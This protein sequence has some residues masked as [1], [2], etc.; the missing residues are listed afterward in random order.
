MVLK[1][2]LKSEHNNQLKFR[3]LARNGSIKELHK[4][5]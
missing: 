5:F 4:G 1:E 3:E 2:Q